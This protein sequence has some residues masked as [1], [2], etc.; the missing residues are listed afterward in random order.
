M[1]IVIGKPAGGVSQHAGPELYR[2]RVRPCS[3]AWR[4]APS[5]LQRAVRVRRRGVG[6]S[7]NMSGGVGRWRCVSALASINPERLAAR[8][9][10]LEEHPDARG[11]GAG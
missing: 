7:S 6:S 8:D 3:A 5:R 10:A 9:S 4:M 11:R 2:R 1:F